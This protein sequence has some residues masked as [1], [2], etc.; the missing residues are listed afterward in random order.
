MGCNEVGTIGALGLRMM[1][2]LSW[3]GGKGE[4]GNSSVKVR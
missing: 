4:M 1:T 2:N 3:V